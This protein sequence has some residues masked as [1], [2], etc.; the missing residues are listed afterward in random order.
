MDARIHKFMSHQKGIHVHEQIHE[1]QNAR[2]YV[3]TQMYFLTN[4]QNL[5]PTKYNDF[6]VSLLLVASYQYHWHVRRRAVTS[7]HYRD[8]G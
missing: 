8:A 6:T 2:N 3:P 5:M 7:F 1:K 4:P